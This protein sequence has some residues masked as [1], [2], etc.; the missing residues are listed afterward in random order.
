MPGLMALAGL[1]VSLTLAACSETSNELPDDTTNHPKI[2]QSAQQ[3]DGATTPD[4]TAHAT[5]VNNSPS[6]QVHT[7][8]AN[9]KLQTLSGFT[10]TEIEESCQPVSNFKL[11]PFKC[12][13]SENAFGANLDALKLETNQLSVYAYRSL[14][15]C[16]H[17]VETRNA[18]GY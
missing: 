3:P 17:A 13:V 18:N 11:K 12:A 1:L 5:A 4:I 10:D 16:Q 2:A 7:S 6:H 8:C 15:D 9:L 14:K